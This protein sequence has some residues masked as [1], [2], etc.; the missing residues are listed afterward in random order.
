M[1]KV[2]CTHCGKILDGV[3]LTYQPIYG[4]PCSKCAGEQK[5]VLNCERGSKVKADILDAGRIQDQEQAH[6]FLTKD[7]I[8]EVESLEV[9]FW[10]SY[11]C[12]KE[13]P[14]LKFNTVHF[15]RCG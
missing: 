11:I 7:R 14:G 2:F 15:E 6:K 4:W 3:T 1:D 8:Y 12:L 5:D 10:M 13:F 9:G